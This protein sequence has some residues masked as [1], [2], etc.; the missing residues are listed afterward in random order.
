ME[1]EE[2]LAKGK[3]GILQYFVHH[4]KAYRGFETVN[5]HK[6]TR[7]GNRKTVSYFSLLQFKDLNLN[8]QGTA[9]T[10][11]QNLLGENSQVAKQQKQKKKKW[12]F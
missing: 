12:H 6:F 9:L 1:T 3:I 8:G 2:V 10:T 5:S 7:Q 4:T 11:Q